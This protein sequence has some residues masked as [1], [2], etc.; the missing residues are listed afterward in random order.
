MRKFGL[1]GYPLSHSFSQKYFREKFK[2]EN[3]SD[4]V[5]EL[6]PLTGIEQLPSLLENDPGLEGLNVT[7]PYKQ[8]VI[9]FLHKLSDE[10]NVIGAVNCIKITNGR[11]VGYNTDA[12]GFEVSLGK[13]LTH[14][15]QQA[16][17]LGTGGS[18]KAVAYV[19]KKL[20]IQF[21][22]VS[23]TAKVDCISYSQIEQC[24]QQSNLFVNTTPLGMY[25]DENATPQIPFNKLGP[26]DGVF[27]LIYNPAETL[28]L[29]KA[30]AQDA[31][32]QNGLEMLELQAE[33]SWE[34]WNNP[35]L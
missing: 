23:R 28:L 34:I 31:K 15:Q 14:Q 8:S 33:K 24:M 5:Y 7:I 29:K 35:N 4:S 17:I 6:F 30:K 11:L 12:Y 13:I 21:W 20:N 25:P 19:L 18:S 9:P 10:A 26:D 32:T 3:I 1:I 16:F 27:D 2:R 22:F